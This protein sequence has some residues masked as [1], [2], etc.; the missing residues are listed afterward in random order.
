MRIS[1]LSLYNFRIYKD[2]NVIDLSTNNEKNIIVISGKNG[3]GKTTFLMSLVWCLY[4]KNM[5]EVDEFYHEQIKNQGGYSKYIANSL[6]R[7][8]KNEGQT[9]FYVTLKFVDVDVQAIPCKEITIRRTYDIESSTPEKLELLFDGRENELISEYGAELFIRDFIIPLESAKFFFFDAEKIVSLA[10]ANDLEQRRELSKAYSEVLGIKKYEDL[11]NNL[12][13]LQIRYKKDS[14]TIEDRKLLSSLQSQVEINEITLEYTANKIQELRET[15]TQLQYDERQ[16]QQKL[17]NENNTITAEELQALQQRSTGIE[18]ELNEKRTRL[19]ELLD[20]A[21]FAIAG[22][23]LT[24]VLEQAEKE[25]EKNDMQFQDEEVDAKTENILYELDQQRVKFEL[26]IQPK[27]SDFYNNTFRSLIRKHF[28][29]LIED[30]KLEIKKIQDYNEAELYDLNSLLNNLKQSYKSQ[31]KLVNETYNSYVSERSNISKKLTDAESKSE[32]ELIKSLREKQRDIQ[33]KVSNLSIEI[34]QLNIKIG[35]VSN[36][37][38]QIK[39]QI[40]ALAKK[41]D[42]ADLYKDKDNLSKELVNELKVFIK[43]YKEAKKKSLEERILAGLDT[44]MHKKVIKKVEVEMID[45]HINIRIL[46]SKGQEIPKESLSMGEKQL[47]ATALLKALVEE[48]NINFP[49]FVDS[50]MQKFD[51]DHAANVIKYFYPNISEQVVIF[52]ILKKELTQD[53]FKLLNK[54]ISKCYLINNVGES[55]SEFE[56]IHDNKLFEAYNKRYKDD[57]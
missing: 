6:N 23:M 11:S 43:E 45:E 50:P 22:D 9:A 5:S 1:E 27:I 20:L 49:V 32:D 44:L 33:K 30:D 39:S 15:I 13:D 34:D 51:E 31:F 10:E 48:S 17:I 36:E 52:P 25:K 56:E 47:Y 21:P 42:T 28:F 2:A 54:H 19:N 57:N 14:A 7:L 53:E 24:Q 29:N 46:N 55:E 37:Q 35:V 3:Y 41:I 12:T 40:S 16:I 38:T 18:A 4:G 8:A 26:P